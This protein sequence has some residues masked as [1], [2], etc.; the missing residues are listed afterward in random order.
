MKLKGLCRICL[1]PHRSWPCRSKKECGVGDCRMR[2]HHLLHSR[3]T[4]LGTPTPSTSFSNSVAHQHHHST[5][6][7]TLLRYL[8]VTLFANGKRVDVYAFLDDGSSSTMMEAEVARSLGVEGPREPLYLCWTGDMTRMEKES[9]RLEITITGRNEKKQFPLKARTVG[10]LK[11]PS[12][13]V[14]YEELCVDHPYLKKIPLS[15]YSQVIPSLIIGVDNAKLISSLK[16]RDSGNSELIAAKTRLGW[17][18]YGRHTTD[19]RLVEYMN[20]HVEHNEQ[21]SELQDQFRQFLAIEEANMK[22]SPQSEEDKR[23]LKILRETTRRVGGRLESGLLWRYDEPCLPNSYPMAIRR[24]EALERKLSKNP[25]LDTKVRQQIAEYLEKGYAHRITSEEL[26]FTEPG[27]VWYLPLGVVSNP[28]K[29]GKVRLIWDA[30]A[31]VEGVSFNDAMLK[32][33][34]MLT[35]LPT[36]LIRFRQK[37]VAFSGD[38]REMFHQFL[39][40]QRDKQT[41]RFIFRERQDE[42]PQIFVMDVAT[43]GAACSPYI[44][45]YLTNRNA[46]EYAEQFPRAARAI[47]DNH[48]VDDYLDSLDTVEEAVSLIKEVKYVHS[49]AGLEIRNFV[50]NSTEVLDNIGER[51]KVQEKSMNPE[52]SIERVLGMVWRPSEDVFSFD[53]SLKEDVRKIVES[54]KVP[55]KRQVLRTIM[56]LFDPLGLVAHYSVH[57]KILMQR[58]WRTGSDWDEPISGEILADWRKWSGLLANINE[59]RVPRCYF[60]DTGATT[61]G[62]QIHVF[63]DASE[64]AYACVA[65]LRSWSNGVP[66]CTLIE[67]KTKVAPLK[68]LSIPRL[69]LQAALIGSRILENISKALTIPIAARFLW[70]DSSTVL[71]WLRS[72]TRRYHQFVGFRVGEILSITDIDEW[73]KVPSKVNIA[74]QATKWGDG[75]SF[76]PKAWW[77]T[78]PS[79][80]RESD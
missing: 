55:T 42:P 35:A 15:S 64:N 34:D 33:P 30:A 73:R 54:Q 47:T 75:P 12:Q 26:E 19:T 7:S 22:R 38:I 25:F 65:Y 52:V 78:G 76:D 5:T 51:S 57:G 62:S 4:E 58:I 39:I 28:R 24:M 71:A 69:E 67:A 18:V 17:C 49:M 60:S 80:L 61:K 45:Q 44:A 6:T 3:T 66:R 29:P 46:E 2:H 41:Q 56:S 11:L 48:Y 23:A 21:V 13:T 72:E 20:T 40:R 74:D 63:V 50:S 16:S 68:P 14:N 37:R 32:G 70:S 79:F 53:N 8:P 77:Y 59:V 27:R 10:H 43:L 1:I 31:R 9:Q 36:I